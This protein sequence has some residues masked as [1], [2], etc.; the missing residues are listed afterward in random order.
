MGMED[1]SKVSSFKFFFYS[2]T[3]H[4]PDVWMDSRGICR[5]Q[6]F[7]ETE[8]MI[9]IIDTIDVVIFYLTYS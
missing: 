8:F 7:I 3:L 2:V 4:C 6:T 5:F 1:E 9:D